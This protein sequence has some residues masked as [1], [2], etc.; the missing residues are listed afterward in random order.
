MGAT[1]ELRPTR[2]MRAMRAVGLM[3]LTAANKL[4]VGQRRLG[5][6]W[7]RHEPMVDRGGHDAT[8]DAS[9]SHWFVDHGSCQLRGRDR[10]GTDQRGCAGGHWMAHR[11]RCRRPEPPLVDRLVAGRSGASN[12]T[13]WAPAVDPRRRARS[14]SD[15]RSAAGTREWSGWVAGRLAP[16][17]LRREPARLPDLIHR[18]S[19]C[20]SHGSC[21]WTP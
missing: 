2:A 14:E 16:P 20:E 19:D 21:P 5:T 7:V 13:G 11:S 18:R 9:F 12:R 4:V 10:A 1:S 6:V 17:G 8:D 15:S 3:Y